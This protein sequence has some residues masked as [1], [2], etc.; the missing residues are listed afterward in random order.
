M[1]DS[2]SWDLRR[3]FPWVL[4]AAWVV[5]PFSAGPAF[6]SALHPH[7]DAVRLTAVVLLWAG[8]AVVLVGTLVPWPVGLTAL[9]VVAPVAAAAAVA[10]AVTDRPSTLASLVAVATTLVA[11]VLALTPAAG[12]L[13]VNGPAYPNE[14]RFPLAVPG[15]LL[16][17]PIEVAW[18][19][20]AGAPLAGLL[21]LAARA[22]VA[23]AIVLVVG[24]PAAA[25]LGRSLHALSRR[26]VVFVPAGMVLHDPLTLADP[27]LFEKRGIAALRPAPAESEALDLTQ[28]ALGLA[29]ELILAEKIPMVLRRGGQSASPDRILL[30]PTRPGLVMQEAQSRRLPVG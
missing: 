26:W 21:M 2:M 7:S 27:V 12:R 6:G 17:G 15:P 5:L 22:W 13:Y 16:F 19:V 25:L 8:W 10:A 18:A 4:R 20:T 3:V 14:R 9:R 29:L 30:T 11:L 24:G 28:G 1:R 23:G